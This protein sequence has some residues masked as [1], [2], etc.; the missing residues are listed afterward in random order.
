[1]WVVMM[2]SLVVERFGLD[3]RPG[4]PARTSVSNICSNAQHVKHWLGAI[5]AGTTDTV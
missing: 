4:G 2:T 5:L 3:P 1:V